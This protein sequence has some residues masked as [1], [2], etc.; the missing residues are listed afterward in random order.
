MSKSPEF[1]RPNELSFILNV[2][3]ET[4]MAAP[5]CELPSAADMA[6]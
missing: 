6:G 4:V 5:F 3:P 1:S 2:P